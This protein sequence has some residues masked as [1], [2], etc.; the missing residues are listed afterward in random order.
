MLAQGDFALCMVIPRQTPGADRTYSMS[1]PKRRDGIGQYKIP[2]GEDVGKRAQ[3]SSTKGITIKSECRHRSSIRRIADSNLVK[4]VTN[5][6][7]AVSN[8]LH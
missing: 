4:Y 1:L 6:I 2:G 5:V 7:Y 3:Y 8:N